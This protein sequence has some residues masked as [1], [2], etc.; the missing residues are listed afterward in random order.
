MFSNSL[1]IPLAAPL[2]ATPRITF[3]VDLKVKALSG[4]Q[5]QAGSGMRR[6]AAGAL[7]VRDAGDVGVQALGGV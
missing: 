7:G 5:K 3:P 6:R 1:S 4:V 2:I